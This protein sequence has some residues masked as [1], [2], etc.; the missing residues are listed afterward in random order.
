MALSTETSVV[1]DHAPE[2]RN[3]A[4]SRSKTP[5]VSI[6]FPCAGG[7]IYVIIGRYGP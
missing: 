6:E 5:D 4:P 2:G 3:I 7:A 1:G